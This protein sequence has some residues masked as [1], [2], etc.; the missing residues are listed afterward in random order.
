M[1][2]CQL[3]FHGNPGE[4]KILCDT[5]NNSISICS[6]YSV[7]LNHLFITNSL[8]DLVDYTNFDASVYFCD[9]SVKFDTVTHEHIF[10]IGYSNIDGPIIALWDKYL[11]SRGLTS[12]HYSAY[13]EDVDKHKYYKYDTLND[14]PIDFVV[15]CIYTSD[16]D[17]ND[18]L[19][20]FLMHKYYTRNELVKACQ[21]FLDT[22][23][24]DLDKLVT[25]TIT[26]I[27]SIVDDASFAV[28]NILP[29]KNIDT[30][31]ET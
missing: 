19:R 18:K 8:K 11:E 4:L 21:E 26:Y 5:F 31:K 29:Y 13:W 30:M 17:L 3:K 16:M 10:N 20:P 27:Q 12:I 28:Y 23:E 25:Y 2:N 14:Y 7:A 22:H 15:D 6:D 9:E 1:Y 24:T